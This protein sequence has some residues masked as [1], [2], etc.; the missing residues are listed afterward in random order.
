VGL[1]IVRAIVEKH[2]GAA[3]AENAGGGLRITLCL[4]VLHGRLKKT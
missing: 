3:F 4:P 1:A 2:H